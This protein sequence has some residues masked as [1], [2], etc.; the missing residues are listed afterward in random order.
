MK[1]RIV[2]DPIQ[3]F[4]TLTDYDFVQKV[5]NTEYFQRLRRLS[6]LGV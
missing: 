5:I 6:Q 1:E 3:D 4:I 2:R